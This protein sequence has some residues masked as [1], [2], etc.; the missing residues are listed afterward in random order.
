MIIHRCTHKSKSIYTLF[1]S[2][3][4]VVRYASYYFF[5]LLQHFRH[6]TSRR[7]IAH[8]IKLFC[9]WVESLPFYKS[10]SVDEALAAVE[11]DDI[12]DWINEQRGLGLSN[13]TIHNREVLV[14]GMFRWLTTEDAGRVRTNIPWIEGTIT[15]NP[16]KALPRFVTSEQVVRLLNGMH[17]EGQR[18]YTHCIYDIGVRVSE[19][20][21]LTCRDLPNEADWPDYVNYY[22]MEIKG[23][24]AYDRAEF[25]PRYTIIS[26]PMLARIRRYHATLGYKLAKRWNIFDRNK[27]LFL[28]VNGEPLTADGVRKCIKAA[29]LRQGGEADGMSPH[30]LRHGTAAS[31]LRSE[32]GKQLMDNLI[33]LKRMLG[34]ENIRTTEMYGSIPIAA[35]QSLLNQ[36]HVR[37]RYLEAQAILDATYR[38]ERQHTEK[39]GRKRG[40]LY[41]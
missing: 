29:W 32:L 28:N 21:R 10:L 20:A 24:K 33:I 7:Q 12:V 19:L 26:R 30:R 6:E 8:V 40:K 22:P 37:V 17:D 16:H 41:G 5:H 2:Q 3:E 9:E 1:D 14:R 11:S 23:S 27:P 39:R 31:V 18:T 13:R 38:P 36:E 4:R 35:L 34:H 15:K 25:K